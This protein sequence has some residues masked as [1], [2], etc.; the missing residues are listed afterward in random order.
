MDISTLCQ[1]RAVLLAIFMPLI[2]FDPVSSESN[3][4]DTIVMDLMQCVEEPAGATNEEQIP[5]VGKGNPDLVEA[6]CRN[7]TFLAMVSCV[8]STLGKC[9]EKNIQLL[10]KFLDPEEMNSSLSHFCNNTA[11]YRN[12]APC[13]RR[14]EKPVRECVNQQVIIT[15]NALRVAGD[16][17]DRRIHGVC[18]GYESGV[19]CVDKAV[20]TA[21]GDK[22]ADVIKTVNGGQCLV[23]ARNALS[24]SGTL[25]K[26]V[27][28]LYSYFVAFIAL[29]FLNS[30]YT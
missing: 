14:Q 28:D 10:N 26:N 8:K 3:C 17:M 6:A 22:I 19:L 2:V 20:R 15:L 27:A 24:S 25:S 30:N 13:L 4:G 18:S 12:S 21:C 23:K 16:S 29:K 7:G 1:L 5:I 9:S 11:V